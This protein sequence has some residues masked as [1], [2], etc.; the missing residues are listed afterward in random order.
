MKNSD[1]NKIK[2]QKDSM[3]AVINFLDAESEQRADLLAIYEY[4]SQECYN[5]EQG[6]S[7]FTT[8]NAWAFV[9]KYYPKYYSSNQIALADDLSKLVDGE[10]NGHAEEMLH[11]D[12]G[13]DINN[14]QIQIDYDIVHREI[15][16]DAIENFISLNK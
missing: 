4:L 15:Y 1:Y 6:L 14:P 10:I 16:E 9:E 11:R 8:D 12:Y 7:K 13:G 5:Y 3:I 2:K